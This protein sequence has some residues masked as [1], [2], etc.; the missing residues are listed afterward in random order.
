[1]K[2]LQVPL[3]AL[4]L[5]IALPVV[6]LV[7]GGQVLFS[8]ALHVVIWTVWCGRG[9]DVLFVTSDS[10]VWGLYIRENLLPPLGDRVIIL[11]WSERKKWRFSLARVAFYYFGGQHEYNPMAV[12]FR[13]FRRARVF[14]FWK[15]FRD[16]KNGNHRALLEVE[17]TFL[18]AAHTRQPSA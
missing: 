1:M 7:V 12:V 6:L 3:I 10:P 15:A 13:P 16:W 8:I 11:N 5:V 18:E 2:W 17:S 14:R 9:R 4:I